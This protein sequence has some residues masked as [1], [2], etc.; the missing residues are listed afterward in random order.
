MAGNPL[1]HRAYADENVG[2]AKTDDDRRKHHHVL[3]L[4]IHK[5]SVAIGLTRPK[6]NDRRG[7]NKRELGLLLTLRRVGSLQC[8]DDM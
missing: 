4:I 8:L 5:S 1:N 3:K 6:L 2:D 7:G